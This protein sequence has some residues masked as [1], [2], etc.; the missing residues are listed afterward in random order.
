MDNIHFNQNLKGIKFH[1]KLTRYLRRNP[2][3]KFKLGFSETPDRTQIGYFVNHILDNHTKEL[4]AFIAKRIEEISEK[5]DI[6]L[7]IKTLE[8]KKPQK[9][10]KE[11]INGYKEISKLRMF[12]SYLKRECLL[13]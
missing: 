8:P 13:L 11:R 2:S 10:T 6:I 1:T 4:I 9:D 3:E 12:V 7:D 5:Y